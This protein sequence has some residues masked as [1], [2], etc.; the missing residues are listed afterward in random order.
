MDAGRPSDGAVSGVD[1]ISQGS[2]WMFH[3]C[4]AGLLRSDHKDA[5]D[6]LAYARREC[7]PESERARMFDKGKRKHA[8]PAVVLAE[9]WSSGDGEELVVFREDGPYVTDR[10][11]PY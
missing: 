11:H 8:M 9:H 2:D 3:R 4:G 6:W 1:L 5:L 7:I 10:T